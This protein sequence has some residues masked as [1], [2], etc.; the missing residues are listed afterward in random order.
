MTL[1]QKRQAERAARHAMG[2]CKPI[3]LDRY[4]LALAYF[5]DFL[6]GDDWADV[7]P[8]VLEGWIALRIDWRDATDREIYDQ[9]ESLI[10]E[11]SLDPR[12]L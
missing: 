7:D 8:M 12:E 6:G 2:D 1:R 11:E 10:N 4:A 5:G 3:P 9:V